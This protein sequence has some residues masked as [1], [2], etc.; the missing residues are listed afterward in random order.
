MDFY[1]SAKWHLKDVV[2]GMRDQIVKA[3]HRVPVDWTTRAFARDYEDFEGSAA[4]AKEEVEAIKSAD[5][6]I[7][8]SDEGGK[9]KYVDLGIALG[10]REGGEKPTIY[11]VGS[12]ANESQFYFH[13]KVQRIIVKNPV[14]SLEE[15]LSQVE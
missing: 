12:K 10:C 9:G 5:V 14:D 6:F 4:Y 7:H 13:P 2:A 8:L 3:G 15:I 11:V 1:I